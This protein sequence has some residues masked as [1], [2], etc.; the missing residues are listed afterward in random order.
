V[1]LFFAAF[2][3][4]E[5]QRRIA[6]VAQALEVAPP[7]SIVPREKLHMTLVF[8]GEQAES[9]LPALLKIG[10]AQRTRAFT[11]R[12]D[13][14]EYWPGSKVVVAVARDYP[15]ALGQL[16]SG[17]RA[18]LEPHELAPAPQPLRPHVSL[19][20]KVSQAPVPQAMSAFDWTVRGF[21]L[22]QSTTTAARPIYTVLGTWPLLDE[23]APR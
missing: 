4:M 13:A 22:M 5:T 19:A 7:S 14:C 11:L 17:L 23:A 16:W 9:K 15:V 1:R 10:A 21:S 20:R 8:V 2:P 3:D 6:S 12:F 18:M